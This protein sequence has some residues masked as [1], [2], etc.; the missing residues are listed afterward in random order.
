[1]TISDEL[2]RAIDRRADQH[3]DHAGL[4]WMDA[5]AIAHAEAERGDLDARA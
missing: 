4:A 1:M 3:H 2:Q 5:Y